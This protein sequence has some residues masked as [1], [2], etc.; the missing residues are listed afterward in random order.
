[1]SDFEKLK[2][3]FKQKILEAKN[4]KEITNISSEIF[5][6]TNQ[7]PQNEKTYLNPITPYGFSKKI[8]FL[9]LKEYRS[10]YNLKIYSAIFYNHNSELSSEDF[11][12]NKIALAFKK[13]KDEFKCSSRNRN[14]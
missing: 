9:T 13:F 4:S 12:I 7:T 8:N 3:N 14:K 6:N 10:F 5:G 1:M 2:N 11:V